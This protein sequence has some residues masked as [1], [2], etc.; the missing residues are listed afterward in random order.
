M[1]M[2]E[3]DGVDVSQNSA[4]VKRIS[5]RHHE[6]TGSGIEEETKSRAFHEKGQAVFRSNDVAASFGGGPVLHKHRNVQS[7][8]LPRQVEQFNVMP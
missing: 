4:K 7:V 3:Y 5:V 2:A 1:A 8:F 6:G